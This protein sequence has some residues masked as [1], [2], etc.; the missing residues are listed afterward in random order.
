MFILLAPRV[1]YGV[2]NSDRAVSV[3]F[4]SNVE[5]LVVRHICICVFL[6]SREQAVLPELRLVACS[7]LGAEG[8]PYTHMD[9]FRSCQ[10]LTCAKK[11][12]R[13]ES[14]VT[15]QWLGSALTM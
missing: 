9:P 13:N 7:A 1:I 2:E 15:G 4:S 6:S 11:L 5:W 3:Y 12:R 14:S 10:G 8:H